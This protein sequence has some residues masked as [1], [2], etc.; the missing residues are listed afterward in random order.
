MFD[1]HVASCTMKNWKYFVFSKIMRPLLESY[2][3]T[4]SSSSITDLSR[5]CSSWLDQH[6]SLVQLRPHVLNSLKV[7]CEKVTKFNDLL[8]SRTSP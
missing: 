2:D 1:S 3:R 8:L 7:R 5:T 4:V 6:V